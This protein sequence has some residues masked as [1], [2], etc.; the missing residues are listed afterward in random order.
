MGELLLLT[1]SI[2]RELKPPGRKTQR[3]SDA[4][5]GGKLAF[6]ESTAIGTGRFLLPNSQ[7][8]EQ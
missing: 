6:I 4:G 2:I 1:L 8:D 7:D 3:L 5:S